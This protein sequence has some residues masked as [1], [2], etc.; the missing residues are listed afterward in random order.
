MLTADSLALRAPKD[1]T[2]S[3][4]LPIVHQ[5]REA[6][7]GRAGLCF[8]PGGPPSLPLLYASLWDAHTRY[9][10]LKGHTAASRPL[11]EMIH[12]LTQTPAEHR[13]QRWA[14]GPQASGAISTP[15]LLPLCSGCQCRRL[16]GL[17]KR[18]HQS[19]A[20]KPLSL[21]PVPAAAFRRL[22]R[23]VWPLGRVLASPKAA[24]HLQTLGHT[25]AHTL[26]TSSRE[27]QFC[28]PLSLPCRPQV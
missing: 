15:L 12:R 11:P 28:A 2:I 25:R 9:M 6:R 8:S 26:P 3:P 19:G 27:R 1:R 13:I 5:V 17:N 24:P 10:S 20:E 23:A 21:S 18:Q 7:F 16:P 14:V 22:S 4:C